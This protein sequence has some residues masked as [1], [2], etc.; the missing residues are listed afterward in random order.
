MNVFFD[1]IDITNGKPVVNQNII[2]PDQIYFWTHQKV[3]DEVRGYVVYEKKWKFLS[4]DEFM[5]YFS[6]LNSKRQN[7]L[8]IMKVALILESPH[9]NEYDSDYKPIRPA[10]GPTG[11]KIEQK[12][13]IKLEEVIGTLKKRTNYQ[14]FIINPV[15][16]QASCNHELRQHGNT[17]TQLDLAHSS[18]AKTIRNN[19]WKILFSYLKSDFLCRLSVY[20]PDLIINACT[21]GNTNT[22]TPKGLKKEVDDAIIS[23][24]LLNRILRNSELNHPSKW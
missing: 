13:I 2:L 15:Q 12:V 16:Y 6:K 1:N 24:P 10:N 4:C 3:N 23:T 8:K 18:S 5:K 17:D 21:G 9:I 11:K 7:N 20:N 19:V 22:K 14:I